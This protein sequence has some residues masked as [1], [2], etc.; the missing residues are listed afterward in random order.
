MTSQWRK[1]GQ[2]YQP[3]AERHPKLITHAANPLPV[4]LHGD[5]YRVYYSGR[6]DRQRSSIG[7]VDFDITKLQV[8]ED[9]R[10]PWFEHGVAGTFYQDGVSIGDIYSVAGKQYV[11]FMGWQNPSSAHWRG[12]IGRLRLNSDLSLELDGEQPFLGCDE[13]DKIS[14]SYPCVSKTSSGEYL[15]L[16]GSTVDWDAGNGEMLHVI[17][18]AV[19]NDGNSWRRLGRALPYKIGSAQAFSKPTMLP[20]PEGGFEVWFSYRGSPGTTYQIGYAKTQD[21]KNWVLGS[22]GIGVSLDGWDSEMI[23]YPYVFE[24]LGKQYMLYN[25]NGFGASGIGLAER[26]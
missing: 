14:L 5:V 17:S 11:L 26:I 6:D 21:S 22:A 18:S 1:L 7:A 8:I 13:I 24:H 2:I 25:G 12:D 16:Y 15:M 10:E 19:S 20:T 4:H 3:G 9:H 23:E